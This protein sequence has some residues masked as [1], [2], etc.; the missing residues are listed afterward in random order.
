MRCNDC[1]ISKTESPPATEP[2]AAN[3]L[4]FLFL[5]GGFCFTPLHQCRL[6][7]SSRPG[8]SGYGGTFGEK[9]SH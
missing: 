2:A 9:S 1:L 5:P 6:M 7:F 3:S 8:I 4:D